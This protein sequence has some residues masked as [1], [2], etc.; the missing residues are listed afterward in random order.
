MILVKIKKKRLRKLLK[1]ILRIGSLCCIFLCSKKHL[2]C[3]QFP[4]YTV[5][6]LLEV[7]INKH[8]CMILNYIPDI[9]K[10]ISNIRLNI[11]FQATEHRGLDHFVKLYS[12]SSVTEWE[13]TSAFTA[14]CNSADTTV[15]C[16]LEKQPQLTTCLIIL[17][18]CPTE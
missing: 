7:C 11:C 1:V 14:H 9:S 10:S 3:Y 2:F 8:L 15:L 6:T 16:P 18:Y 13:I 12:P 4:L 5:Y 17:C